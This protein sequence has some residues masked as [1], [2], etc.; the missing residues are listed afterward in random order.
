MIAD[1]TTKLFSQKKQIL[2]EHFYYGQQA[3]A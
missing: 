1:D 3:T 2:Y